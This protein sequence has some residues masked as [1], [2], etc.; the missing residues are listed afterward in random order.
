MLEIGARVLGVLALACIAAWAL[1][2]HVRMGHKVLLQFKGWN[3]APFDQW[4][5]ADH[6]NIERISN[7]NERCPSPVDSTRVM[8]IDEARTYALWATDKAD[9][10]W[11]QSQVLILLGSVTAG[12]ALPILVGLTDA[13]SVEPSNTVMLMV[14]GGGVL[15]AAF[16]ARVSL[17]AVKKWKRRASAYHAHIKSRSS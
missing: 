2:L 1:E 3:R 17:I 6:R 4:T 5:A 13:K 14:F 7:F 16:G 10:R 11:M 15:T 12:L 8:P 9:Q